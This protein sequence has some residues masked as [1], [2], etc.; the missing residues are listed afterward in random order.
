M[1]HF[2]VSVHAFNGSNLRRFYLWYQALPNIGQSLWQKWSETPGLFVFL[3]LVIL[4][5]WRKKWEIKESRWSVIS[6]IKFSCEWWL[7]G[8][9]DVGKKGKKV[10]LQRHGGQHLQHLPCGRPLL[11]T[12][13]AS[14]PS[15]VLQGFTIQVE[16]QLKCHV[17]SANT[18]HQPIHGPNLL[19]SAAHCNCHP[20]SR[21]CKH[22]HFLCTGQVKHTADLAS[23]LVG[24]SRFPIWMMHL[25]ASTSASAATSSSQ[26][27]SSRNCLNKEVAKIK[28]PVKAGP[29]GKHSN[30]INVNECQWLCSTR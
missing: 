27:A 26:K 25:H 5:S 11:E 10:L 16:S 12:S 3:L 15:L 18:T 1:E 22:G 23:L 6:L 20:F 24:F 2:R 21:P 30:Y 4:S 8:W 7:F 28:I 13:F 17:I 9:E 19:N 14:A 29:G